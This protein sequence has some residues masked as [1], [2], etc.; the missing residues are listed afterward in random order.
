[1]GFIHGKDTFVSVGGDNL[2]TYTTTSEFNQSNDSHDVTTYGSDG[3]KFK[4]G[5]T[6]GTFTMSGVYDDTADDS[7]RPVLQAL[8]GATDP[9]TVIRQPEGTGSSLP[10]DSF[11]GLLTSYRES[12]PVAD[13]VTWT[14]E[15]QISG[16]VDN[17][18][19]G[20]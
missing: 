6:N 20:A 12:S 11:D 19:Q 1:M 8:I 3:H 13:M 2:S 14:A 18:A 16:D 4:G 7:P 9:V 10:Q 17:D 5:L 15:F